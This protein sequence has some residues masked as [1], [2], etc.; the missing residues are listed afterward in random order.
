MLRICK[1]NSQSLK[2]GQQFCF[3]S[4]CTGAKS[5]QVLCNFLC[6]KTNFFISFIKNRN[7][8]PYNK[9]WIF[10]PWARGSMALP[11]NW[12]RIADSRAREAH[13]SPGSVINDC[14]FFNH[15]LGRMEAKAH[16]RARAQRPLA[17]G[18]V[19][20]REMWCVQACSGFNWSIFGFRILPISDKITLKNDAAFLETKIHQSEQKSAKSVKRNSRVY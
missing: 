5:T 19:H 9:H 2:F 6:Q 12:G 11:C 14:F 10:R 20:I 7:F 4:S 16:V 8:S 17:Y 13:A 3:K 15:L 1:I 18:K